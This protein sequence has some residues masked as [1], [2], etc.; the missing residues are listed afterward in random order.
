MMA[1]VGWLQQS[2]IKYPPV[3]GCRCVC[4]CV[5]EREGVCNKEILIYIE[6][7][8]GR[9]Y[10]HFPPPLSLLFFGCSRR[11]SDVRV[12][13]SQ[14]SHSLTRSHMETEKNPIILKLLTT[15]TTR[16]CKA[17]K[18][19]RNWLN[20]QRQQ[21]QYMSMYVCRGKSKVRKKSSRKM[22]VSARKGCQPL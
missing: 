13:C 11:H 20:S 5:C 22:S 6:W 2:C 12:L 1:L 17:M 14:C 7:V 4:V 19:I 3:S 21:K 15:A 16:R 10:L 9:Q 8:W 18:T